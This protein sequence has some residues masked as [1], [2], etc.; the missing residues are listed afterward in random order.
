MSAIDSDKFKN[1]STRNM[2]RRR[3]S[4]RRRSANTV[5]IVF[6]SRRWGGSPGG[7]YGPPSDCAPPLVPCSPRT[8]IPLFPASSAT[9]GCIVP[10]EIYGVTRGNRV[11]WPGGG[12]RGSPRQ[13]QDAG[14]GG[15]AGREK[16][17][18]ERTG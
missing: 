5:S 10:V 2:R 1:T 18:H 3:E 12:A 9:N 15:D 17:W 14:V 13:I 4:R 8:G 11:R 6:T 16:V 7:E